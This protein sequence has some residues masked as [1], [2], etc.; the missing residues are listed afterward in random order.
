MGKYLA[1][2]SLSM[3]ERLWKLFKLYMKQSLEGMQHRGQG[4]DSPRADITLMMQHTIGLK[5]SPHNNYKIL[6][7]APVAMILTNN[8]LNC[9]A[10]CKHDTVAT[11][12]FPLRK[13]RDGEIQG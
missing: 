12:I 8:W 6:F 10:P 1:C 3:R 9:S 2:F 4:R 5:S 11:F 13:L 7:L